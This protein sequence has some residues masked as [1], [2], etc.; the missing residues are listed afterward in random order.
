MFYGAEPLL[1]IVKFVGEAFVKFD[2][3]KSWDFLGFRVCS[4]LIAVGGENF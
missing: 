3:S 1:L 2:P 4:S